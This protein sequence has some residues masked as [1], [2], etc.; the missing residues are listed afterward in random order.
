M[1][2]EEKSSSDSDHHIYDTVRL[3]DSSKDIIK[4]RQAVKIKKLLSQY[5]TRP[6]EEIDKNLI[7][8]VFTRNLTKI[9]FEE[10]LQ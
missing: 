3:L 4:L 9:N 5:K 6:M 8:G 10:D 1:I 2:E 7:K